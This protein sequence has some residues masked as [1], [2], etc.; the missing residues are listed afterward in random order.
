MSKLSWAELGGGGGGGTLLALRA[1]GTKVA[2]LLSGGGGTLAVWSLASSLQPGAGAGAGAGAG[3]LVTRDYPWTRRLELAG[4]SLVF[5]SEQQ[6]GE[7]C[8]VTPG[9]RRRDQ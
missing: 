5:L 1:G 6:L 4:D 2:A 9:P 3:S 7:F 8:V